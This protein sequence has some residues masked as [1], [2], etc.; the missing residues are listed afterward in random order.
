MLVLSKLFELNDT[1][2]S[3]KSLL[4]KE[5]RRDIEEICNIDECNLATYLKIFKGKNLLVQEGNIWRIYSAIRPLIYNNQMEITFK[6]NV[7]E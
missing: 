6:I 1:T 3:T 7:N 2:P 4:C 5:N